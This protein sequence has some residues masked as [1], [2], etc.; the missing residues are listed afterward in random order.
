MYYFN[1]TAFS[2][3]A[4]GAV[5]GVIRSYKDQKN[6]LHIA[7]DSSPMVGGMI[8]YNWLFGENSTILIGTGLGVRVALKQIDNTSPLVRTDGELRLVL[9]YVL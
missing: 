4:L 2:G 1:S 5:A 7:E 3:F 8:H 9:G 6:V